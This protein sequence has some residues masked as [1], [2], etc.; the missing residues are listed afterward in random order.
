MLRR[1][2]DDI[3]LEIGPKTEFTETCRMTHRQRVLYQRIKNKISMKDLFTLAENKSKMENLMNLV[4]Q[5][6]KVCNHPELFERR[7]GRIPLTFKEL[8]VGMQTNPLFQ[9]V[10]ELRTQMK[11]PISF[12]IPKLMFDECFMVSDNNVRTYRKLGHFDESFS[13]FSIE[14]HMRFFNIFNTI[15]LYNGAFE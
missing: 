8:Q 7:I 11:N 4:M 3:E 2:K 1:L 9:A 15:S 10:P 12:E 5:F 13:H 6:R 14:N